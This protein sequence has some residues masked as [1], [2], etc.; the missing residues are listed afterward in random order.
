MLLPVL[1]YCRG[2]RYLVAV[3]DDRTGYSTA[4]EA[5]AIDAFNDRLEAGGHRLMA[6]GLVSPSAAVVI[7]ARG[8][9][10][11]V[12]PG[13]NVESREYM[14]GFWIIEAESDEEAHRL[15]IEGSRACNRKVELRAFLR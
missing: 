12:T 9:S 2:M 13:P 15:A 10:E 1:R 6:A 4:E 11:I 5:A 7:D 14:S 3:I 8:E